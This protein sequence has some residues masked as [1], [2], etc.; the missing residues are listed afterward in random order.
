MEKSS[1]IKE[2]VKKVAGTDKPIFDFQYME[3]VSVEGDICTAKLGNLTIPNIRL[4]CIPRGADNGILIT[5]A[6]G[7]TVM[8]ADLSCGE[9]RN[10]A[11]IGC[12]EIDA[13]RFHKDQTTI[14]ANGDKVKVDVGN[15]SFDISDTQISLNGGQ[16]EGIVK[17]LNLVSKLNK[18]EKD[19]NNL[20]TSLAMWTP[21][22]AGQ[23]PDA[24]SLKTAI[25]AWAASGLAPTLREDIENKKV[26]H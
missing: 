14:S 23:E 15:S 24:A 25:S 20:K 3:V 13:I 26:K 1:R 6:L 18:I 19:V 2:L 22:N 17:V 7:S 21:V 11:V 4:A 16:N 12:T 9:L 8:V 10:M 5:P